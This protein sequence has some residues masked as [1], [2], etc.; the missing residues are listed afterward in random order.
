MNT[1]YRIIEVETHNSHTELRKK[2][3]GTEQQQVQE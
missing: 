1:I 2:V 3:H